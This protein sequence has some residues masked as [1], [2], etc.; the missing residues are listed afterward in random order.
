MMLKDSTINFLHRCW[1]YYFTKTDID[2][3]MLF[4]FDIKYVKLNFKARASMKFSFD[5]N[6]I[7]MWSRNYV[8]F[9]WNIKKRYQNNL[10]K[11]QFHKFRSI[12]N[13]LPSIKYSFSIDRMAI[14]NQS[15][16]PETL[17]WISSIFR[18]IKN[19]LR[20]I[21]CSFSI[22]WIGIESRSSHPETLKWICWTFRSIE[23]YLWLIEWT[24]FWNFT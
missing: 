15:S 12:E 22:D 10:K 20:S 18:P 3:V 4:K 24:I 17:W 14:E 9:K 2:V 23:K 13:H 5:L 7:L 16:Q 6:L 11:I 19:S 1:N 8:L 21:K